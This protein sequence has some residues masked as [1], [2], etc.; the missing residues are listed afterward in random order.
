MQSLLTQV[1]KQKQK[2]L[3]REEE[4]EERNNDSTREKISVARHMRF[5]A[6]QTSLQNPKL[7]TGNV[8]TCPVLQICTTGPNFATKKSQ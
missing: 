4:E 6:M 8:K 5:V 3:N 1:A 7:Y 2:T